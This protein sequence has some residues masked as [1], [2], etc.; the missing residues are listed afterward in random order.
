MAL[1]HENL[2]QTDEILNVGWK[3]YIETLSRNLFSTY[4][5]TKNIDLELSI[6]DI[7]VDININ[8]D[9]KYPSIFNYK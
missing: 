6:E 5:I 4:N 9:L 1:V 2:Y 3:E 8:K 7:N